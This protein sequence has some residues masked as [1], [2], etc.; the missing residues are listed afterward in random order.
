MSRLQAGLFVGSYT[1]WAGLG[2]TG[3]IVM[4]HITHAT[5]RGLRH[6]WVPYFDDGM[7]PFR[8]PRRVAIYAGLA[9]AIIFLAPISAFDQVNVKP[10]F[11]AD[12]CVS[13][14]DIVLR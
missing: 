6:A 12:A 5:A 3:F 7:T 9:R 14:V 2:E 11:F 10:F 13:S 8:T 4:L 1:M